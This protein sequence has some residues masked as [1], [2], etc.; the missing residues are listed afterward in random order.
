MKA[1]K[2]NLKKIIAGN[3]VL[4]Y[5]RHIDEDTIKTKRDYIRTYELQGVPFQTMS[6]DELQSWEI[7]RNRVFKNIAHTRLCL[8]TH[9]IREKYDEKIHAEFENPVC[10]RIFDEYNKNVLK[11]TYVVR[12]FIS[13]VIRGE[14]D[15]EVIKNLV[16][17]GGKLTDEECIRF[18]DDRCSMI[19]KDFN[20]AGIAS[21]KIVKNDGIAFSKFSSFISKLYNGKFYDI[22]L[23]YSPLSKTIPQAGILTSKEVVEQRDTA[24]TRYG[25]ML[26]IEDFEGHLKSSRLNDLL[27]LDFEFILSQSFT[28]MKGQKYFNYMRSI[29]RDLKLINGDIDDLKDVEE[30]INNGEI[31]IG[32]CH[33]TFYTHDKNVNVAAKNLEEAQGIFRRAGIIAKRTLIET[34]SAFLSQLPANHKEIVVKK[35]LTNENFSSLNPFYNHDYGKKEGNHWGQCIFQGMTTDKTPYHVNLHVSDVG[36]A[37]IYGSVGT[38][39][40]VLEN[41]ILLNIQKFNPVMNCFDSKKNARVL[42]KMLGGDY[43]EFKPGEPTGCLPFQLEPTTQNIEFLKKLVEIC[44]E[45]VGP[46]LTLDEIKKINTSVSSFMSDRVEKEQRTF[47]NFKQFFSNTGKNSLHDRIA[48]YTNGQKLGWLFD[49][50]KGQ[51]DLTNKIVGF[52]TDGIL[53]MGIGQTPLMAFLFHCTEIKKTG[54]PFITVFSEFHQ[55]LNHD[56][57]V[58]KAKYGFKTDRDKNVAYVFSTQ[59]VED[60]VLSKIGSTIRGQVSTNFFLANPNGDYDIYKKLSVTKTE[61]EFIKRSTTASRQVIIKQES[62]AKILDF[63]LYGIKQY[64]PILSANSRL[65]K[66]YDQCYEKHNSNWL[67]PYL[68]EAQKL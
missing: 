33:L 19:E 30:S 26:N 53:N 62:R 2:N 61:F 67:E 5:L 57:F 43:F 18:L 63:N 46:A 38:G 7:K 55:I 49:G 36:N 31:V 24:E 32:Q 35:T 41:W 51:L 28:Y 39:K 23:T 6:E 42:I 40:T 48:V 29:K 50:E 47:T 25:V 68:Q 9:C 58:E 4:P 1:Q 17:K 44:C 22:P 60:T 54:T 37:A 45:Q 64:L 3:T 66:L 8:W 13:V 10:Q 15:L 21:L 20:E 56:Y 11:D 59:E 12:Y 52:D 65:N 16:D 34:E 14:T 27:G